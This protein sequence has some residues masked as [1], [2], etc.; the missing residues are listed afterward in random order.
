MVINICFHFEV[1]FI[2]DNSKTESITS[3]QDGGSITFGDDLN[4]SECF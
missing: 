3:I 4:F 1:S 2:L